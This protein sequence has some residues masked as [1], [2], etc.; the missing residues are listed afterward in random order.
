MQTTRGA[1]RVLVRAVRLVVVLAV[2]TLG[3]T[4]CQMWTQFMGNPALTGAQPGSSRLT[5]A[6]LNQLQ[7]HTDQATAA[8]MDQIQVSVTGG[9]VYGATRERVFGSDDRGRQLCPAELALPLCPPRWMGEFDDYE[10]HIYV[11]SQPLIANGV[12]YIL[13]DDT[14]SGFLLAY[15]ADGVTNCTGAWPAMCA[16]LW[17]AP[18]AS[19]GAANI[20]GGT[21]YV[22]DALSG[23][24]KA[25]DG[26]GT[27]GCSGVP[28]TCAPRWT[29]P[30]HSWS[31]PSISGDRVLV[32]TSEGTPAVFAYDLAGVAGCGGA[33]VTCSPLA[34]ISLP[35]ISLGSVSVSE[36]VGYVQ[37]NMPDQLVA[38][39][40]DAV[41]CP[42]A[43][44]CAPLWSADLPSP[45]WSTPAVGNGRVY[46]ASQSVLTVFDARG[47][48][49]CN[50][51]T[52][53]CGALWQTDVP[54]DYLGHAPMVSAGLVFIGPRI[55]DAAGVVGCVP[56]APLPAPIICRPLWSPADSGPTL[57][58]VD[59][60]V[61]Q[62]TALGVR[63]YSLP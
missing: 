29:A 7:A 19:K 21:V 33:P 3:L 12:L 14:S 17:R 47:L 8:G 57:T 63:V 37:T 45:S 1:G 59:D 31:T 34:T 42:Q 24:L 41:N 40:A 51:S 9:L 10:H 15:D 16:P 38:I 55:Y 35:G 5:T 23:Q 62:G 20:A 36:G 52:H 49:S 50:P 53:R 26:A 54:G 6:N 4:G 48:E 2:V 22:T 18:V 27:V 60:H 32:P 30:V 25:F 58:L 44:P 46:A 61:Y 13:I 56:A 43:T 28:R 11:P 39:D